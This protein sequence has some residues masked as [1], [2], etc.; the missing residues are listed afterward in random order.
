MFIIVVEPDNHVSPVNGAQYEGADGDDEKA[1]RAQ[2]TDTE[3]QDLRELRE[4]P[5][6]RGMS[7]QTANSYTTDDDIIAPLENQR[8][9]S[10]FSRDSVTEHQSKDGTARGSSR[11]LTGV[12]PQL[13]EETTSF[14]DFKKFLPSKHGLVPP[15]GPLVR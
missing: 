7:A 6:D 11:L 5:E 15:K 1:R 3:D 14:P 4:I 2:T 13:P 12:M 8:F 9:S 10:P